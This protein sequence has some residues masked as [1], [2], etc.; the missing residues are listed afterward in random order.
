[1]QCSVNNGKSIYEYR[2]NIARKSTNPGIAKS[3]DLWV[4]EGLLFHCDKLASERV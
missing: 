3:G 1:V 4:S 2:E